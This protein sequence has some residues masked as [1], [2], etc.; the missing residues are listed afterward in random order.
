LFTLSNNG[1]SRFNFKNNNTGKEWFFSMNAAQDFTISFVGTGGAEM[2]LLRDGTVLM[3]PGPNTTFNL[4]PTGNLEI[5]GVLTELSD[6]K[7]KKNI[8]RVDGQQVL[9][10][11]VQLPVSEWSYKTDEE[12]VRHLGPMAQDFHAAFGL[13]ADDRH[14][15][16]MDTSGVA[17][18]AIQGL[19]EKLQEKDT[20]L[21]DQQE[22]IQ[23][24]ETE[25]AKI[26]QM[27]NQR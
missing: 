12:G 19:N 9:E 6:R 5:G 3:G 18:A 17:L 11:V 24:L 27:L 10:K 20:L 4:S 14:V 16:T 13:G 21:A 22:R 8:Q 23:D 2:S 26:R 7:G 1:G 25:L 15:A